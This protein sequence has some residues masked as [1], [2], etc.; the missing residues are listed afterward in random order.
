MD[1]S[2]LLGLHRRRL[3]DTSACSV[4]SDKVCVLRVC[5]C[6]C[7]CVVWAHAGL[8][9][10]TSCSEQFCPLCLL[11]FVRLGLRPGL[12]SRPGWLPAAF[13]TG[14][15]HWNPETPQLPTAA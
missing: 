8:C 11:W 14:A 7:V 2:L 10:C 4:N 9:A 13:L 5:V 3:G 6:V 15:A 12:G 1:Y